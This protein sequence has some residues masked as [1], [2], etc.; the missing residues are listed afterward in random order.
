MAALCPE[1]L[2]HG[3][4]PSTRGIAMGPTSAPNQVM[5]KPITPPK[6][7]ALI[8]IIKVIEVKVNVV[9]LAKKSP[10]LSLTLFALEKRLGSISRVITEE[11]VFESDAVIDI[12]LANIPANTNPVSPGGRSFCASK[13]Y[14]LVES[15]KSGKSVGANHMGINKISGHIQY[16]EADNRA[17]FFAVDPVGEEMNRMARFHVPPL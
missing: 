4:S 5:I 12:V 2:N 16:K 15:S 14:D 11:I 9:I 7:S 13:A 10:F 17:A 3:K 6:D 8:A 1:N